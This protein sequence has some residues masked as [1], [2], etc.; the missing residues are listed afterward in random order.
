MTMQILGSP[1]SFSCATLL[2]PIELIRAD[3]GSARATQAHAQC[4]YTTEAVEQ[5]EVD[6]ARVGEMLPARP[7]R[8]AVERGLHSNEAVIRASPGQ[9]DRLGRTIDSA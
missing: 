6:V 8:L 2:F 9:Q 3:R 4:T 5:E 1:V 7:N